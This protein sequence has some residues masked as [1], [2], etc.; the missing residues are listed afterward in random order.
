[1]NLQTYCMICREPIPENRAV[2]RSTTCQKDCN[3]TLQKMRRAR[4]DARKCRVCAKPS[5]P[6]QRKAFQ[7]FLR[8]NP[9]HR[10]AKQGRPLK[11]KAATA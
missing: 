10:P 11:A 6:D 8:S 1:M 4:V 7:A 3:K 9:E 2:N 5:T